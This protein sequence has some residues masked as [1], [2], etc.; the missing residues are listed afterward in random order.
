MI[1]NLVFRL[2]FIFRYKSKRSVK[3][4]VTI[5]FDLNLATK[6]QKRILIVFRGSAGTPWHVGSP[7]KTNIAA[8]GNHQKRT[9]SINAQTIVSQ[10]NI[11]SKL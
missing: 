3:E 4:F 11:K 6:F 5:M 9:A 7:I 10:E 1:D 8:D 2:I